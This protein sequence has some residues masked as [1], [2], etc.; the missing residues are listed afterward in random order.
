M[1]ASRIAAARFGAA[2]SSGV[3][4]VPVGSAMPVLGEEF[5]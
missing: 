2:A 4:L 5:I 3:V 1:A